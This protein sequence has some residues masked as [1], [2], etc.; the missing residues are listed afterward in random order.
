[1]AGQVW[2]VVLAGGRGTRF[3]PVSTRSRPK[4]FVEM[5]GRGTLL[6]N[7]VERVRLLCPRERTLVLTG[8]E[9]S[10]EVARQLPGLPAENILLEPVPRN[11]APSI[12][13]AAQILSTRGSGA[14]LMFVVPSDHLITPDSGF[15]ETMELALRAAEDGWLMTVGVKPDRPA[16]GYGYL[17]VGEDLGGFRRVSSFREKPDLATAEAWAAGGRHLWNAGIFAWRAD[18][19]LGEIRKS[20][21]GL[22]ASLAGL[23]EGPIPEPGAFEGM[24]SISVDYGVMENASRVGTVEARFS[25]DDVGDWPAARRAGIGRGEVASFDSSECTVWTPGMLTVLLGVRNL[26]VVTAGGVLLVMGDGC[27]QQLRDVVAWMEKEKPGLV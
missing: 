25:W 24:P 26:S 8:A 12:G 7:T 9:Y 21:P 23:G 2:A 3:W 10:S 11:T 6:Q 13:W 14:D 17:E 5:L 22:F 19:I 4:Q 18:A 15:A 27:S 20:L 1:M 16:T